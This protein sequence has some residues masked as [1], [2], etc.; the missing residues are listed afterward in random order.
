MIPHERRVGGS[1]G[2]GLI[3]AEADCDIPTYRAEN[4][5]EEVTRIVCG[6]P[7][8]VITLGRGLTGASYSYL[9]KLP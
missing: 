3:T 1:D 9:A 4:E 5:D 8:F 2:A 7:P 6:P